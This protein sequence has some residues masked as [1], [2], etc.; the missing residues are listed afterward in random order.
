MFERERWGGCAVRA[1]LERG[2]YG[3]GEWKISDR[4]GREWWNGMVKLHG[5]SNRNVRGGAPLANHLR[6]CA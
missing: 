6:T 3:K 2:R 4:E 5:D 1:R